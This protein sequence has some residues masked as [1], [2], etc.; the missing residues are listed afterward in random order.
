MFDKRLFSLVPGV[1]RHIA[2]NVALQWLALL[3]N[4]V[5]FVSVGRLLQSVLAGGATGID[6]AR[7]LLVAVVAVAVRLGCQA[8]AT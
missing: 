6:L 8:Q 3:A 5:L 2:G 4:V 1:V 7:T